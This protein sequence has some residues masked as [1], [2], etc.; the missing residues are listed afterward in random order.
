MIPTPLTTKL[1]AKCFPCVSP[2]KFASYPSIPK[3]LKVLAHRVCN[4]TYIRLFIIRDLMSCHFGKAVPK[5]VHGGLLAR[6]GFPPP[7]SLAAVRLRV[8]HAGRRRHC[9]LTNEWPLLYHGRHCESRKKR[10]RALPH[11]STLGTQRA[12]CDCLNK[13]DYL[14]PVQMD[15]ALGLDK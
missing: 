2:Q 12:F 14:E 4:Q 13:C 8:T 9:F 15:R 3:S 6:S 7:R 10:T 1:A 5:A 11:E